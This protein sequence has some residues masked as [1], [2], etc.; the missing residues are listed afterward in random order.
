MLFKFVI[1]ITA[2][3]CIG[4]SS[5]R[6]RHLGR[7]GGLVPMLSSIL[8][9][10]GR[11]QEKVKLQG[12]SVKGLTLLTMKWC[13]FVTRLRS[14]DNPA[15]QGSGAACVDETGFWFLVLPFHH[16]QVDNFMRYF[17]LGSGLG[18]HW[19]A[20]HCEGDGDG[21]PGDCG[22]DQKISTKTFSKEVIASLIS[23]W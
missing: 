21:G 12:V 3:D 4:C 5:R 6:W 20:E 16:L 15:P 19:D 10:E 23:F 13:F 17:F 2:H 7:V 18:G 1:L 22:S 14:C 9:P 11:R 8:L